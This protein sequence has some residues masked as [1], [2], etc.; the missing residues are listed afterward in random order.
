MESDIIS[1][2]GN[3]SNYKRFS[4][5]VREERLSEDYKDIFIS[6]DTYF[7]EVG[8]SEIDWKKFKVWYTTIAHPSITDEKCANIQAICDSLDAR[9]VEKDN[10]V[11]KNLSTRYWAEKVSDIAYDVSTG[12]KS[13]DDIKECI[14]RYSFEVK[15]T[16]WDIEGLTLTDSELLGQ[17]EELR[18]AT[19]Y[20]WSIPE[21]NL[22][23]GPVQ[24]GDLIIVGARPDGGK[25]TFLATQA[26]KF[27]SQLDDGEC[28]LWCNNEESG[29]RI[30]LRQTQAALNWTR[31]EVMKNLDDSV[32]RFEKKVGVNKIRVMDNTSMTIYD[33]EAAI[34]AYNP[35]I[36][37]ID[38]IWK[39]GGFE[40]EYSGIDRYAKLAQYVRELAK[41][42]GPII[43]ASQIDGTA[44]N[45]KYPQMGTLYG[46][47]T[48]VQGEADAILMIG[49][50]AEEGADLRFLRA[51]KNKLSGAHADFRSAGCAIKLDKERAQLISLISGGTASVHS[52]V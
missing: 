3:I 21:L 2:L 39:V 51:P 8:D 31:E 23:L 33:I 22:M 41:R 45:V 50:S 25:T 18:D 52:K 38:Q 5:L 7:K 44:D 6:L 10:A 43:C 12:K 11:L 15:G 34:E 17:L 29:S 26:V 4:S 30:R 37:F 27:A 32:E 49:Q 20:E 35:K 19:K 40:K 1:L 24:K 47:K 46:S 42:Y 36:I 16:E 13:F 14:Q 9:P 48:S 28:V